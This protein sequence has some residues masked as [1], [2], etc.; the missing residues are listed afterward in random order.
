[1]ERQDVTI[2]VGGT[3]VAAW[4]T[5]PDGPGPHPALVAAH[6]F[7]MTR[8]CRLDAVADAFAATGIA[9]VVFDHRGFGDSGGEPQ[10]LDIAQ[11]RVDWTTVLAW[12]RG[13]PELD[14][15][16]IGLWGTS[17]SGGH[18]LHVAARDPD[19]ACVVAQVPFTDGPATLR[20]ARRREPGPRAGGGAT[21]P[22]RADWV[23]HGLD[24]VR[25]ALADRL[26][27][28]TGRPPL[29]VPV[30]GELGTGAVIAGPGA[31]RA[32]RMLVPDGVAWRNEVAARIA[33]ELPRDRPG[34]DAGA[35]RCPLLVVVCTDDPVTPPAPAR[36]AAAAAPRG[37]LVE[38]A[39]LAHF[40]VYVG[41]GF[42]RANADQRAWLRRVLDLD[43]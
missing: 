34:R 15:A 8:A 12:A 20:P 23:R 14:P 35:I 36:A 1:M 28:A 17:F 3:T 5:L 18:V 43:G 7:A 39:D 22:S 2:P 27:A 10:V 13:R 30:A 40:D 26:R 38:Y 11:Q 6:G 4:L 16:R 9:T 33:L 42:A 32:I 21:G 19:L 25:N 29:L 31:E 41:E 37:E 24:L